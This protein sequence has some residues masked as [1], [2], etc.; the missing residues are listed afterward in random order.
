MNFAHSLQLKD[1]FYLPFFLITCFLFLSV[2]DSKAALKTT[3]TKA[4]RD[5]LVSIESKANK[6]AYNEKGLTL[7][8]ENKS[9]EALQLNIDPALIFVPED[10]SYQDLVIAGNTITLIE[11][12]KSKTIALQS[13]CG[14][15]YAHAPQADVVFSFSKQ[16]DSNM[17][18][19]LEFV[20]RNG[21][22]NNTAQH[23]VWVLTNGHDLGSVYDPEQDQASRKLMAFM[24][25]L[26][27]TKPPSFY[28]QYD[29]N[30]T[31]G[32]AVFIRKTRT[33]FAAIDWQIDKDQSLTLAAF[34][35]EEKEI[36]VMFKD[37]EFKAGAYEL[38]TKFESSKLG[39]GTYF[40]RLLSGKQVL[41]ETKIKLE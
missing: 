15:S 1:G 39:A 9:R 41:K 38:T 23:A 29:I 34:D 19:T 4:L 20:R 21:L 25:T 6:N 37:R 14:K 31:P 16:A 35:G 8:I 18:K 40:I 22:G 12:L 30:T 17:I 33:I 7:K 3:L 10:T 32:E 24:A 36:Q 11:P 13:Y 26:L 5:G 28:R 27:N 2:F